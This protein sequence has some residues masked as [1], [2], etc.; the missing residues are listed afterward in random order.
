MT[1]LLGLTYISNE[2][3]PLADLDDYVTVQ[4][5][6]AGFDQHL[7]NYAPWFWSIDRRG[8]G[9]VDFKQGKYDYWVRRI[10]SNQPI[11]FPVL[12]PTSKEEGWIS[13]MDGR[14]RIM[15]IVDSGRQAFAARLPRLL[16]GTAQMTIPGLEIFDL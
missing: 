4:V 13:V 16:L 3:V 7:G 10:G 11:G 8:G 2:K 9:G 15:A 5:P 12:S 6:S 14:H 1:T